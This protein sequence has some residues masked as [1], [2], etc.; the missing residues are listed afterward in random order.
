MEKNKLLKYK[1]VQLQNIGNKIVITNKLLNEIQKK[2]ST[3]KY[4]G[5]NKKNI[6][7]II[8]EIGPVYVNDITL[9]QINSI[10]KSCQLE[11]SDV[12]IFNIEK[13][14]IQIDDLIDNLSPNIILLF[15]IESK[16]IT[17]PISIN[18]NE[19]RFY[20]DCKVLLALSFESLFQKN[21][22]ES[23]ERKFQLWRSLNN[24]FDTFDEKK[25]NVAQEVLSILKTKI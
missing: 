15:D 17:L 1:G 19:I 22:I 11:F 2:P 16:E 20:K 9:E 18:Y 6:V 4:I 12:A 23:T 21:N 13:E 8:K 25:D 7:I 24:I 5:N 3:Y 14:K 10:L